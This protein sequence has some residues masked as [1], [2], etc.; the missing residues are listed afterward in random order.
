MPTAD[1]AAL[2]GGYREGGQGRE[3]GK[4]ALELYTQ[5]KT[6]WIEI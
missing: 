6:V 2:F 3:M 5:T 4:E 1:P